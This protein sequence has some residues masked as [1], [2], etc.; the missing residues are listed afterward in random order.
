MPAMKDESYAEKTAR[1]RAIA[2]LDPG[3]FREL[4]DPFAR[5][6]SP[7]LP[8]QGVVPQSDDGA[9]IA[10]GKI[11]DK[12]SLVLSLEG[13]FQGGSV[14]EVNGAKI[15]GALEVALKEAQAGK[16]IFPVLLLDTGGVRL[17]EANLGLLAIS[18]IHS[19]IV[20]LRDFVPV[21]GVIAGRVGCFGGMGIAAALCSFL[22]GTEI[23]RLGLN[24]P[25]VIE[26]EAGTTEFDSRDRIRIWETI[27]C[28]R[29]FDMG[30]IDKLV[31]DSV[32]ALASAVGEQIS[33]AAVRTTDVRL[34]RTRDFAGQL[35]KIQE[36]PIADRMTSGAS[37]S[38][39]SRGL[40]WFNALAEND[41]P[42]TAGK[43]L[44]V[45][46]VQWGQ[47]PVRAIS[48][49]PDP[50]ARFLQARQG[51]VGLEEGWGIAQAI[52]E[53]IRSDEG[54]MR[55]ALLAIV[56][57]PGQAFGFHE[58][59]LGIHLSLAAAVDAYIAARQLGHPIV[60][61]IVGKAISGAFLAHG[62]Q[63][64]EIL[65]LDD[66]SIEIHVMSEA[67]VARV[68]RRSPKEVSELARI[69]PSTA[70]NVRS[71][72]GL[73][74]VDRLLRVN[75]PD[76]PDTQSVEN[77]RREILEAF[78]RVREVPKEPRTRVDLHS[79]EVT[80]KMSRRV[81]QEIET[82]WNG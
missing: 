32:D 44:L 18:E 81:R 35:Q 34:A 45:E 2:L 82:E 30:Q 48:V 63:A 9:V 26:Q 72:A 78:Q 49:V 17:Q 37:L 59:A 38:P 56:D 53:A 29:R 77:V 60:T 68:T 33:I 43:S 13:A 28:R 27:G 55:R 51:Q 47:E 22:V 61:L 8:I 41:V 40:Q 4:L 75:N 50:N 58:E 62:L 46:D 1:E 19:A 36:Y 67:S 74:G 80:R 6:E 10:R 57:V 71:F 11:R 70:R 7:H 20:A 76:L 54:K 31:D 21:I 42:V 5:I 73:G 79:A 65:A 66:E 12:D 24:G 23:G 39:S 25:E 69:A 3:T 16:L 64:S 52:W 14:G 15:A